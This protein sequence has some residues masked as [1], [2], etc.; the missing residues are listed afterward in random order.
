MTTSEVPMPVRC[1]SR[2][3][4]TLISDPVFIDNHKPYTEPLMVA[5]SSQKLS[6]QL[7]DMFGNVVSEIGGM[8]RLFWKST[9]TRTDELLCAFN[10]NNRSE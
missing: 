6:L 1:V 7:I 4:S 2:E 5:F 10:I 9:C 3:W 8:Q